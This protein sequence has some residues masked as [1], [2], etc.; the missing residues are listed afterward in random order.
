VRAFPVIYTTDVQRLVTFYE[1]LGFA[2]TFRFPPDDDQGYASLS[3]DTS[4]LGIV[5]AD[6]PRDQIGVNV[7][8]RPRF[9]MFIYVD[10][11]DATVASL[12]APVLQ[13]PTDMPWGERLAYVTDPDGNPVALAQA[14]EA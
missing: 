3:R 7:G 12:G 8:D 4:D 11:L 2:V 5:N 10:E 13:Q 9:E 14:T 6:F 1:R